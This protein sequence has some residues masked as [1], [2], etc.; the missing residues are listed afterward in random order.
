[1]AMMRTIIFVLLTIIFSAQLRAQNNIQSNYSN[2]SQRRPFSDSN[3]VKNISPDKKWFVRKYMSVSTGF[4]FFNG[5]NAT[6][7]SMP[8][9][10][11]LNRKLSNNW[12]AFAGISA[13]PAYIN[14][15]SLSS[16]VINKSFQNNGNFNNNRLGLN[17]RAELG[18]MYVNDQKTFSISGSISME[19]YNSYAPYNQFNNFTPTRFSPASGAGF[20]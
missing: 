17:P 9:G 18:L 13:T 2:L 16:S 1:M 10:L 6:I 5:G 8:I 19:R 3:Q 12:Y 4:S 15:N 11:Q 14:F 20:R 7:I